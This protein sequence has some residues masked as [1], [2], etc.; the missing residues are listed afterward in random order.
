MLFPHLWLTSCV[1][2]GALS[3]NTTY[4][5]SHHSKK[6]TNAEGLKVSAGILPASCATYGHVESFLFVTSTFVAS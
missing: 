6:A 2:P 1:S 5:S 3:T 4:V